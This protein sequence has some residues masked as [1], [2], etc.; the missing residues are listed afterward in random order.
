MRDELSEM[1]RHV[2]YIRFPEAIGEQRLPLLVAIPFVEIT[3][4]GEASPPRRELSMR[5]LLTANQH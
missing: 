1:P 5:Q 2:L 3:P 4:K